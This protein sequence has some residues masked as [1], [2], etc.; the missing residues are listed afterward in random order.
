[1]IE[2]EYSFK[3]KDIRPLIAYCEVNEYKK[4]EELLQTRVLY[5]NKDKILARMTTN[6]IGE[7]EE[8]FFNFKDES[9]TDDVLKIAKESEELLVTDHNKKFI[10]SMLSML[11]FEKT[12][13]LKRKRYVYKKSNIKFEIDDYTQP[14]MK[15]VAIEGEKEEVDKEYQKIKELL[16]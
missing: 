15:V 3:V 7:K 6:K 14:I 13:T 4:E 8:T 16:Y 9:E 5:H 11:K 2:Y 10:D 1:M 12:K